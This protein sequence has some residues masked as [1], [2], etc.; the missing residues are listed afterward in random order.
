MLDEGGRY[1]FDKWSASGLKED[2]LDWWLEYHWGGPASE[3][4]EKRRQVM[5]NL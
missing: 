2:F 1:A 5:K 3:R 4:E